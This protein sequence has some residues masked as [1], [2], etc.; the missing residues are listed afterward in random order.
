MI[1]TC[2]YA[3]LETRKF[4]KYISKVFHFFYIARGRKTI[5]SI[6]ELSRKKGVERILV[7]KEKNKK[8]ISMD[9]IEIKENLEWNWFSSIEVNYEN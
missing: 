4:A 7:L 3:S 1:T 8:P 2:R 6:I 5:D 9:I